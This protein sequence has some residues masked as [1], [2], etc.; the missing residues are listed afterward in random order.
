MKVLSLGAGVQST[1]VYLL[2]HYGQID[3]L[4]YAIFADVGDEPKAVYRHLDWMRNELGGDTP[5]LVGSKGCLGDDLIMNRNS[6]GQRFASIPAYTGFAGTKEGRLRRQCTKEYKID[7]VHQVLRREV[8]GLQPRQRIKKDTNVTMVFGISLEEARR[9]KGILKRMT[10]YPWMT[11]LFPLID[12]G[13]TRKDCQDWMTNLLP[14]E[15]PR[16][17]CVYCPYHS[18]EEWLRLKEAGGEDWERAVEVDA[19]LRSDHVVNRKITQP[20]YV[21]RSLIPL[22]E[23][24]FAGLVAAKQPSHPLFTEE[25]EGM[26]GV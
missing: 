14:Y 16:S 1:C 9:T 20:M 18:N 24:D 22:N 5:I 10:Q 4:D 12:R 21:H 17:A 6:T 26:C 23:I 8:L 15:V 25:C 11:A 13:W 2:S 19:A 7:V 3:R